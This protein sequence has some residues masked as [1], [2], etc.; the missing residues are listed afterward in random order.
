MSKK[1]VYPGS[2]DPVTN[3]HLDIVER[4]ANI[5]D[6]VIVSVF[7]NPNK[8][9][10]F[11]M[12]E[13]VEMLKKATKKFKN[14]KV[15]SFSGLTT[16]YVHSI[17]GEAILR[18]LRAVSDFEGEFQMA[19]MNKHLDQE[20]ETIFLMTDTKYAFLSSSVIKEAAYFDGNIKDLVPDFVYKKLRNKFKE[21]NQEG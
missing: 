11:T 13:R 10:V 7:C 8:E 20:I 17:G 5:F 16:K 3:G 12:D 18:G 15:D 1:I 19:S 21:K 14:V 4:A 9:P 6:E 2:F